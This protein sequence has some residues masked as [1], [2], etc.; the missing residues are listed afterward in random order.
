MKFLH[1]GVRQAKSALQERAKS[2]RLQSAKIAR[3]S[4]NDSFNDFNNF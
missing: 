1:S 2:A 4:I 3:D